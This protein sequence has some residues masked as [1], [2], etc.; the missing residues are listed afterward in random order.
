MTYNQE[1]TQELFTL[2]KPII[3]EFPKLILYG[4][5]ALA[6]QTKTPLFVDD[7]DFYLP[8]KDFSQ[9]IAFLEKNNFVYDYS[10]QWHTV[11]VTR[12]DLRLEFD[13]FDFWYGGPSDLLFDEE[14]Q[15]NMLGLQ[16]LHHIY[17]KASNSSDQ[18]QKNKEKLSIIENDENSEQ[19]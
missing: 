12:N 19:T 18:K 7:L 9:L 11:V 6:K 4:S 17:S 15:I 14:L 10:K 2:A 5:C 16:G 13:S 3:Q 8:E 1:H